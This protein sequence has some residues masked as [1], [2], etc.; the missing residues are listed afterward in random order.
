[1]ATKRYLRRR[2]PPPPEP[3]PTREEPRPVNVEDLES[4]ALR[5]GID[6]PR[7]FWGFWH[8]FY[9]HDLEERARICEETSTELWK[10]WV[11]LLRS[12][13]ADLQF[14]VAKRTDE[15]LPIIRVGATEAV[16]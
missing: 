1:M 7:G 9:S 6:V 12:L 10:E 16:A 4:Y 5:H 8:E 3:E 13:I 14:E 15:A 11:T 2:H